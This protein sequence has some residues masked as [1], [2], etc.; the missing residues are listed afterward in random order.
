M[1]SRGAND[2]G[3]HRDAAD[4][5]N[6]PIGAYRVRA[7]LARLSASVAAGAS[8]HGVSPCQESTVGLITYLYL[9]FKYDTNG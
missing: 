3:H 6:A 2:P 1:R 4:D 8:S 9:N 5:A 7:L